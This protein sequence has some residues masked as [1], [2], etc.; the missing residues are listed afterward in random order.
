MP[1][2]DNEYIDTDR[3]FGAI[4][5]IRVERDK[6]DPGQADLFLQHMR[7]GEW[8][9]VTSMRDVDVTGLCSREIVEKYTGP[10]TEVQKA[11]A[12]RL[13]KPRME[14]PVRV[15]ERRD[16]LFFAKKAKIG[17]DW[18]EPDE[19]DITARLFG[20]SFDNTGSWARDQELYY[21]IIEEHHA[22]LYYKQYPVIAVNIATL[23]AWATEG[24]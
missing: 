16:L 13:N 21:S 24:W 3:E 23:F 4:T 7:Y 14:M 17:E 20:D 22:V 2:F 18:H 9:D 10:A 1:I 5:R 15:L 8:H 11:I 19:Q 12:E 6:D